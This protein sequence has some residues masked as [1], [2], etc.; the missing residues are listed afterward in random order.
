MGLMRSEQRSKIADKDRYWYLAFAARILL[1]DVTPPHSRKDLES[2][3][4][5]DRVTGKVLATQDSAVYPDMCF[6]EKFGRPMKIVVV[7][8]GH[9]IVAVAIARERAEEIVVGDHV[10]VAL[11][12]W[13]L[14]LS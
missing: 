9:G 4:R 14:L 10:T 12:D 11:D 13:T 5:C 8:E 7:D 3:E 1:E 2:P 6:R